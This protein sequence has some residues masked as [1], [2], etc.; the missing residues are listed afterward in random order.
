MKRGSSYIGLPE[1]VAAK[2]AVINPKNEE[3]EECFKWAVIAALHH[4]HISNNPE[5]ITKLRP[6]ADWKGLEFP[7][8]LNKICKFEKSNS[9]IVVNVL[10]VH[11]KSICIARRSEFNSKRSKQANLLMI[12][13]WENRH[14]VV[15]KSLSKL[16]SSEN[17]KGVKERI[18]IV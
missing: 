5:R 3:D 9:D 10:F 11:D 18:T 17:S 6:F 16:L 13:D 2:K 7:M 1:W 14:Y 12:I 8:A 4:E 15:I